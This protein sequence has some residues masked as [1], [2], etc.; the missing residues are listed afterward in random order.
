MKEVLFTV[1]GPGE[2]YG[3]TLPLARELREMLGMQIKISIFILP[4]QF[5]SGFEERIARSSGLFDNIL[6]PQDYREFLIKKRLRSDYQPETEG[7]VFY[8]G[9]DTWHA[10]NLSRYLCWPLFGYDEGHLS[11]KKKFDKIFTIG[12]DG[13]LMLDAAQQQLFYY[14]AKPIG[15]D[16]VSL[17]LF[18]GSRT[19]FMKFTVPFYQQIVD[20]L[21]V[22]HPQIDP[23]FVINPDQQQ[24][25]EQEFG[26]SRLEVKHSNQE[27]AV[28]L[29]LTLIGTNTA[30][31]AAKG[32]PMIA[33][34][35]LNKAEEIP[36]TG[37][38]G[39]IGYLPFGKMIK[40]G[41]L[42]LMSLRKRLYAIPNVKAGRMIVP[43]YTGKLQA[44]DIAEQIIKLLTDIN[45]R[46]RIAEEAQNV[47]GK[48]GAAQKIAKEVLSSI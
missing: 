20:Q 38:L 48:P 10:V 27:F 22:K 9:G 1:N 4:C 21:T 36:M 33:L 29:A 44:E 23:F 2:L 39:F 19:H 11:R 40:R 3:F 41:L 13:N 32:I 30:I 7:A 16:R 47:I 25:W 42:H 35:P 34:L 14:S 46:N 15:A 37:I 28:D 8:S 24:V 45:R 43:E 31:L 6:L 26:D 5:S 12:I 18:P 17:A